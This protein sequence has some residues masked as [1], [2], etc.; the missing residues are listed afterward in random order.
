MYTRPEIDRQLIPPLY[1]LLLIELSYIRVR[2][3]FLALGA[4]FQVGQRLCTDIH[5]QIAHFLERD[6]G[7]KADRLPRVRDLGVQLVHLLQREPLRLV[8][9]GIDEEGADQTEATPEEKDFE[10]HVGVARP[11]LHHVR[12]RIGDRPVEEPIRGCRHRETLRSCLEREYLPRH[13]PR[14]RA[15]SR[16]EEIDVDADEGKTS[17]VGREVSAIGSTDNSDNILANEH[18][19]GTHE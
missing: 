7:H 13:H 3:R 5:S 18:P 15:P 17:L 11:G 19:Y 2:H 9:Q 16:S 4:C 8:D 14:N 12:G 10:P 1:L 6:R